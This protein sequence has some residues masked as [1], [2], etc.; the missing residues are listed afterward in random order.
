MTERAGH[1]G[2]MDTA[3]CKFLKIIPSEDVL[4]ELVV[5]FDLADGDR[6]QFPFVSVTCGAQKFHG[7]PVKIDAVQGDPW[8]ALFDP[9]GGLNGQEALTFLPL[10]SVDAVTVL[11]LR[12][13]LSAFTG[14]YVKAAA[15]VPTDNAIERMIS[16][17]AG[18]I[19]IRIGREMLMAVEWN[20]RSHEE[21]ARAA[22]RE[23]VL[24]MKEVMN[25]I[26]SNNVGLESLQSVQSLT[27][28]YVPGHALY[29][30]RM[31][32][33]IAITMGTVAK[34]RTIQ[35]ELLRELRAKL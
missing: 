35:D 33:G 15:D 30:H 26:M 12:T 24:A 4:R 6:T 29:V 20:G 32:D 3:F 16:D 34:A 8:L 7:V 10:K 25:S 21:V 1:N 2:D 22:M 19:E 18:A 5:K 9:E 17:L 11:N 23:L 14:G 13:H 31:G 27:L 28:N